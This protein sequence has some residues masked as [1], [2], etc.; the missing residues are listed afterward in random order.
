MIHINKKE[1]TINYKTDIENLSYTY[2]KIIK[3]KKNN[4]FQFFSI[5]YHLFNFHL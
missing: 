5:Y 1:F 3:L 2:H 4:F